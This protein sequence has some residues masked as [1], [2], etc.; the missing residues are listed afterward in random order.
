MKILILTLPWVLASRIRRDDD[1]KKEQNDPECQKSHE[2]EI[3][4]KNND[5]VDCE[6]SIFCSWCSESCNVNATALEGCENVFECA[7]TQKQDHL[8]EIK[9]TLHAK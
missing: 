5:Q 7:L 2:M 4:C 8:V 1:S 3:M 6:N 9:G